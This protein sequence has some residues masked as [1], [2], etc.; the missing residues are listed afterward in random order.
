MSTEFTTHFV[1]PSTSEDLLL[2]DDKCSASYMTPYATVIAMAALY[3][4]AIFY[5]LKNGKK[6]CLPLPDSLHPYQKRL[7]QLERDLQS[8][9]IAE[10]GMEVDDYQI[11]QTDN[12]FVFRGGVYP[13]TRNRFNARV[14]T[15]VKISFPIVK[16]SINLLEDALR[17]S[18]LE[19]PNLIRLLGVS[20]LS[21]TVFRP[22]I[23]LEWLP[24]G[25]LADYFTYSIRAKEDDDRPTVQLKDMLS[26]IHQISLALKYIHGNL[27]EFGQELTHGRIIPRNIL[28]SDQ[29]LK[30]CHVKLG[31][32]GDDPLPGSVPILA[33]LPPEILCCSE[34]VAPHRP[35]ND[36]WMFDRGLS[37]PP[38]CPLDV[39]TL[40][41]DCL[42]EAHIRPRFS[43]TTPAL[44]IPN[45]VSSLHNS[46]STSLFLYPTPD[47][48]SCSCLEHH[49]QNIAVYY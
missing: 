31:D 27:D 39:W 26:V 46:I 8:Y 10:D 37:C 21:F 19:H 34:K 2:E 25:T 35:E 24:G 7:K 38:T 9:L 32:F 22:M 40:V 29:E 42:S 1:N 45:R 15:A 41:T 3:L 49:C 17:L 16:R 13:K 14:T 5:F 43:S 30:K 23:A 18:K 28:I 36:V 33:Y 4:L 11:G 48:S 47:I 6:I 12:G 20:E 44:S